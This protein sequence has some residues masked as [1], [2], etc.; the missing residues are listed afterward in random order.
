VLRGSAHLFSST[1][2]SAALGFFQGVLAVR[3]VGI[4]G[5]GLVAT[6][7]TFASNTNRLLSFRMS[8]VVVSRL[9]QIDTDEKKRQASAALKLAL[10]TESATSI[11]AYLVL[12]LL[13]PWAASIFA[14]DSQITSWFTFYGIILISNL[15]HET[16][17]GILQAARRFEVIARI[18]AAQSLVTF[19]LIGAVFMLGLDVFAILAAYVIGKTINELALAFFALRSARD[20]LGADW[21][22]VALDRLPGK[23]GLLAFALNTNLNG[24]VNL[25]VR[26]NIPLYLG[27]LLSTTAVG[28]FKVAQSLVSLIFLPLDPFIWPTYTEI[29]Q[30]VARKEWQ[31]TRTLLRRVS[32][33]AFGWVIVA[34]GAL[35]LTG[36]FLIPLVYGSDAAPAYPAA[37]IL[38]IGY[39]FAGIFQWN[40]P[41]MLA[42]GRPGFPVIAAAFFGVIELALIFWLVPIYGYLMLAAIL[43]AFFVASIGVIVWRGL[44]LLRYRVPHK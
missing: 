13:A 29:T 23:R 26:D 37:L 7:T 43:S 14:K 30:T 22:Q 31:A 17:T 44:S 40:R 8:E 27:A 20:L 28:Y 12:I 24:T 3:L 15:I 6:I 39:G 21:W 2:L 19:A 36:W 9:A 32:L 35:A 34:G 38:L 42:L 4:D 11:I 1:T 41:L 33:I 16:S 5:W 18:N 10:L 25:I